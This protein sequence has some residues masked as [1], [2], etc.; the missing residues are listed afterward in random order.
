MSE[1][2][3]D[4]MD[5]QWG[6]D[7]WGPVVSFNWHANWNPVTT[8][9]GRYQ[10]ISRITLTIHRIEQLAMNDADLK[11][12]LIAECKA[13]RG[14]LAFMLYDLYGP[15]PLATVEQ[16]QSPLNDVQI[17]RATEDEMK[18]FIE[19]N[20]TEAVNSGTLPLRATGSDYGR[21]SAA[22]CHTVLM[23]HYMLVK[24]WDKA[25][26]EGRELQKA[27]YGF[28][29][30]D[31][32]KAVFTLANEGNREI[33]HA[34]TAS[35]S[36]NS[37][38]WLAHVLPG[39]FPTQNPALQKWGGYRITW[40]FYNTYDANDE[41]LEVISGAFTGTDGEVYNQDNPGVPL[42]KGAVPIKVG[43]DP[44]STGEA[45]GVDWVIYR[46]ADVLTLLGEAIV[47]N[48]DAVTQEAIDLLNTVRSRAGLES[49]AMGDFPSTATY[50][51][52]VLTERGHELFCEGA[53][54]SDLI[55]HSKYQ[56]A[57]IIKGYGDTYRPKVFERWPLP[58]RAIDEGRG[59]VI[60]NEGY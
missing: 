26:A 40:Q 39:P 15:I 4:I 22:L 18:A 44:G 60:Q 59:V 19:S 17:P 27:E 46:Y 58:Q 23:K 9:F 53:R 2:A 10:H 24:Q 57:A 7:P 34:A 47:R 45:S 3:T 55:R 16:L 31:Q 51:D 50:Y 48:G 33:I 43:E 13:L 49:Y 28:G 52:A 12:R 37:T 20:L 8:F 56:E 5:C 21:V 35:L 54:R 11:A 30:M 32:Y 42:A 41:R 38:L 1:M 25:V 6:A 29:L 14:W 36:T